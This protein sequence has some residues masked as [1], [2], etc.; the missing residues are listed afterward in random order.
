MMQQLR[1]RQPGNDDASC[2]Y[3]NGRSP[4]IIATGSAV[5][6]FLPWPFPYVARPRRPALNPPAE[7]RRP[8]F[9]CKAMGSSGPSVLQ[10]LQNGLLQRRQGTFIAGMS[11]IGFGTVY[12]P[13]IAGFHRRKGHHIAVLAELR[14]R[15]SRISS[16]S[17]VALQSSHRMVSSIV[18][19][20]VEFIHQVKDRLQN[21]RQGA[22]Q[23]NPPTT[24][25]VATYS[26]GLENGL[27]LIGS[28]VFPL[29][30]AE[31]SAGA[32]GKKMR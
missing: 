9:S 16:G 30:R 14:P 31:T 10:A 27:Y 11:F 3:M 13:G 18:R 8:S 21:I 15:C 20:Q 25:P 7:D 23:T 1:R 32:D 5:P 22:S 29:S 24:S 19:W 12:G 17:R 26:V 4:T 6:V 2:E 28:S